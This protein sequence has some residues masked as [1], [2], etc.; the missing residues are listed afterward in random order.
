M[1]ALP[2]G[3]TELILILCPNTAYHGGHL[4]LR[5]V[6]T[7]NGIWIDEPSRRTYQNVRDKYPGAILRITYAKCKYCQME[8]PQ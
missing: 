6:I 3:Q 4:Y 7:P 5:Y 2:R 8:F 1:K